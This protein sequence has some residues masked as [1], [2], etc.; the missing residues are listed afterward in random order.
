MVVYFVVS[1]I[2][3]PINFVKNTVDEV[4]RVVHNAL[5]NLSDCN[6][7]IKIIDNNSS[8]PG[9]DTSVLNK[10]HDDEWQIICIGDIND[11]SV[12]PGV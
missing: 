3:T 6:E 7:C 10:H 1:L 8:L 2:K 4:N 5:V 11:S 12:F 9:T